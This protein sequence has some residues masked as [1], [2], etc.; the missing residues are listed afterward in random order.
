MGFNLALIDPVR[1]STTGS[2]DV[3][4]APISPSNLKVHGLQFNFM[5]DGTSTAAVA[6]DIHL[7]STNGTYGADTQ[8]DQVSVSP[9]Q[10]EV[11]KTFRVGPG[12]KIVCDP[13]TADQITVSIANGIELS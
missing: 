13:D 5:H 7:V 1:L 11:S 12:G 10:S 4:T 9:G 2:N 8:V 3:Y 6:V